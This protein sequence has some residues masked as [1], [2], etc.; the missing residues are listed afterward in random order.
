ML[1]NTVKKMYNWFV[2]LLL[3]TITSNVV[4]Q[5]ISE[6]FPFTL[7]AVSSVMYGSADKYVVKELPAGNHTCSNAVFGDPAPGIVKSCVILG[8]HTIGVSEGKTIIATKDTR[9]TYGV[10]QTWISK[11][12]KPGKYI[13]NAAFFEKDPAP[14]SRKT[15]K[16]VNNF[17]SCKP[18]QLL[19]DG[20][21]AY[22]SKDDLGC[23][24]AWYCPKQEYPVLIVATPAKCN[25]TNILSFFASQILPSTVQG[26]DIQSINDV[27]SQNG[28]LNPY[29]D[30]TLIDIWSPHAERIQQLSVGYGQ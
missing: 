21:K 8:T 15:C 1:E 11:N 19:G 27:I 12:I 22:Y 16:E 28:T 7:T 30:K 6:K 3:L 5:S 26:L 23:V 18:A 29:K 20:S 14:S 2:A 13:C 9:V 4:A 25:M 10:G 17:A 24:A